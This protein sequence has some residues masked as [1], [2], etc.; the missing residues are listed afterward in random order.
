MTFGRKPHK[1]QSLRSSIW[2]RL[3]RPGTFRMAMFILGVFNLVAR[4]IDWFR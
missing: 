4:V 3:R 1:R 2:S